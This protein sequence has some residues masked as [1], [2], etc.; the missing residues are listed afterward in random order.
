MSEPMPKP[1]KPEKLKKQSWE[2]D[3]ST[4]CGSPPIPAE[5]AEQI[6][7]LKKKG[8]SYGEIAAALGVST[9]TAFGYVTKAAREY[10]KNTSK[11][12]GRMLVIAQA[13]LDDFLRAIYDQ[14]LEGDLKAIEVALKIIERQTK[15]A[16]L[17]QPKIIQSLSVTRHMGDIEVKD[18]LRLLAPKLVRHVDM[19]TVQPEPEPELEEEEEEVYEQ[20]VIVEVQD[21]DNQS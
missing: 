14:C 15:L 1:R 10:A 17:D 20:E 12:K 3:R 5:K 13:R 9:F 7:K 19:E 16:G 4:E 11:A 8:H 6:F 2:T 18:T 21:E